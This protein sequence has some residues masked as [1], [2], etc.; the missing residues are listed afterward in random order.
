M[1]RLT[2]LTVAI[3]A[4]MFAGNALADV[5]NAGAGNDFDQ[6]TVD[7]AGNITVNGGG[8]PI[9]G[10]CTVLEATSPG[11]LQQRV[12][13][14]GTTYFQ[15]IIIDEEEAIALGGVADPTTEIEFR[16][17][18]YVNA[19]DDTDGGTDLATQ[20]VIKEGTI[21]TDFDAMVAEFEGQQGILQG[22]DTTSPSGLK[23]GEIFRQLNMFGGNN[24]RRGDFAYEDNGPSGK[25][26]AL[27]MQLPD[28]EG[29]FAMRRVTG[30]FVPADG[31]IT[32]DNSAE[33]E[34]LAG[35]NLQIVHLQ[36]AASGV[37]TQ[38][39]RLFATTDVQLLADNEGQTVGG[40]TYL[41]G[42]DMQDNFGGAFG[43]TT[44]VTINPVPGTP[45]AGIGP[46]AWDAAL[47]G[48]EPLPYVTD[49]GGAG[50]DAA[51]EQFGTSNPPWNI[52]VAPGDALY[53]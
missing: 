16:L 29:E 53:Q 1:N 27:S 9:G 13:Y 49:A 12:D 43:T 46:F 42:G 25:R 51:A 44:G 31:T 32:F 20:S 19:N 14:G 35:D 18:N 6:Y 7:A 36:Q 2:K 34:Y 4:A 45:I 30:L 23:A 10:T 21:G 38:D 40:V 47:F 5:P 41:P 28:N 33:V 37:G 52:I 17:E 24:T 39:S 22:T 50:A 15:T 26:M 48:T 3:G 8:C 11:I